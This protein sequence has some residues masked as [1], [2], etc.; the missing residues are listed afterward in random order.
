MRALR[1]SSSMSC[2]LFLSLAQRSSVLNKSCI[3]CV[4]SFSMT[5][6]LASTSVLCS[7]P[8]KYADLLSLIH[9]TLAW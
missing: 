8:I 9:S 3:I 1:R 2:K 5:F 4:L 6:F 7:S